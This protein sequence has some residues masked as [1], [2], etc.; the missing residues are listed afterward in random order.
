M[1]LAQK[2]CVRVVGLAEE[3]M[4]V[5]SQVAYKPLET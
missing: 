5:L 4:P 1:A 2:D 3:L